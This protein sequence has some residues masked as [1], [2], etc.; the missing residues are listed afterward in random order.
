MTDAELLH[1]FV[2]ERSDAAFRELVDRHTSMVYGVCRR[3]LG[4]NDAD[5]A[6]QAVFIILARKARSI[7]NPRALGGWLFRTAQR[8][9]LNMKREQAR[10]R[11]RET[12][13]AQ[14]Q[15]RN[16]M[17][18][19]NETWEAARP[20]L[21]KAIASLRRGQREAVVLHYLEGRSQ[22]ETAEILGC[23]EATVKMR[24]S[25]AREKIRAF[26]RRHGVTIT[27]AGLGALLLAESAQAAPAAVVAACGSA[28][29][30][31]SGA[32]VS[33]ASA[34][35][36]KGVLGTM[37][38]HKTIAVASSVMVV[39][40]L[41][42][43]AGGLAAGKPQPE[44][45][46]AAKLTAADIFPAD[47]L[48]LV[49]FPDLP[50]SWRAFK[51]TALYDLW[52]D[53]QMQEFLK[54]TLDKLPKKWPDVLFH[55]LGGRQDA[56]AVELHRQLDGE[57][58]VALLGFRRPE[59]VINPQGV[60]DPVAPAPPGAP[61]WST[62]EIAY[63]IDVSEPAALDAGMEEMIRNSRAGTARFSSAAY[64]PGVDI[65]TLMAKREINSFV[66]VNGKLLISKSDVLPGLIDRA[67]GRA[68]G[69]LAASPAYRKVL[70]RIDSPKTALR[71]YA[72]TERALDA[73]FTRWRE[74]HLDDARLK[75][76]KAEARRVLSALGA[77]TVKAFGFS[78]AIDGKGFVEKWYLHV[79]GERRGLTAMLSAPEDRRIRSMAFVPADATSVF[80]VRLDTQKAWAELERILRGID[81][82]KH[83]AFRTGLDRLGGRFGIDIE[84]DIIETLG[85]ELTVFSSGGALLTYLGVSSG[86]P[87]EMKLGQVLELRAP[88]KY[89]DAS[90]RAIETLGNVGLEAVVLDG[91]DIHE[92]RAPGMPF[93]PA[94]VITDRY[95]I[96][97]LAAETVRQ[98]LTAIGGKEGLAPTPEFRK[99]MARIPQGAHVLGYSDTGANVQS[100]YR[101][102]STRLFR[103]AR[104][105]PFELGALGDGEV[106]TRHLYPSVFAGYDEPE[107][108][109][110]VSSGPFSVAAAAGAV[111]M[112]RFAQ[113]RHI[114]VTAPEPVAQ[115]GGLKADDP[116]QLRFL[117]WQDKEGDIDNLKA[118]HPSGQPLV[119][120]DELRLLRRR[121]TPVR[122]GGHP[123]DAAFLYLWFSHP[124]IDGQ[125]QKHVTL[126]QVWGEPIEG[127]AHG[128][129][130]STVRASKPAYGNTG[131]I[132]YS[133]SPGT[134]KD[135]PAA[136]NVELKYTLGRWKLGPEVKPDL[137]GAM[138]IG[139]GA[140]VSFLGQS[141]EEKAFI[142]FVQDRSQQRAEIQFDFI[143]IAK[144]GRQ[145]NRSGITTTSQGKNLLVEQFE[146]DLPI[147][148]VESFRL[149]SRP[150]RT[151]VYRNV[152]LPPHPAR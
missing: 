124:A 52:Q 35:I 117:S 80:A 85:H 32:A 41:A 139:N 59:G 53:P 113:P 73:F 9:V 2:R 1:R 90:E 129:R 144:D 74:M 141:L 149:R 120:P 104:D 63:V 17:A 19:E 5:D 44:G 16:D 60:T 100:F 84:R 107:G 4:G 31:I 23:S 14:A 34:T 103:V 48:A 97:G 25:R 116:P 147:S 72:N 50:D 56:F 134:W 51:K 78:S 82:R 20:H 146:F 71:I 18:L 99:A 42:A 109:R 46:T 135:V 110:F 28:A 111:F 21:D 64:A 133:L 127:A 122:M 8:V 57:F 3:G 96:A 37:L 30:G 93:A 15:R 79:P 128:S 55:M 62:A 106:L 95:Y 11:R 94:Y 61:L 89:K 121:I 45:I 150:I 40:A 151:T 70:A 49:T 33:A 13:L 83:E 126:Q 105:F 123:E 76:D 132:V 6:A 102:Y 54:P 77:D 108:L 118:W 92:L 125:S 91:E 39:A 47:T 22:K 66:V 86:P 152:T 136:I 27:G 145:L 43:V 112:M 87:P 119:D 69:S 98:V 38:L 12:A 130:G 114:V 65:H 7:R 140:D 68:G 115:D 131:W 10:R 143:A 58:S 36:A 148:E 88:Q 24:V 67:L 81:Q 101:L 75:N 26:M 137:R 138:S 142:G 29:V